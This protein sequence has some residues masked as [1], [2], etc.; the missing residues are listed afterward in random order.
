MPESG[1]YRANEPFQFP[2]APQVIDACEKITLP[3]KIANMLEEPDGIMSYVVRQE[4]KWWIVGDKPIDEEIHSHR[5]SCVELD[6]EVIDMFRN[7]S[8]ITRETRFLR[9]VWST[10]IIEQIATNSSSVS[11]GKIA[12]IFGGFEQEEVPG[13]WWEVGFHYETAQSH[14]APLQ[15][16]P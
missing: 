11:F 2:V 7:L 3:Q 10:S 16:T 14:L 13:D 9:S 8:D 5:L 15:R 12:Y 1:Y 4:P 6:G